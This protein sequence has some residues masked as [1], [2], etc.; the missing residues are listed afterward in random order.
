MAVS[1][2]VKL[3]WRDKEYRA[4]FDAEVEKGLQ[5]TGFVVLT[6]IQ[7]GI[8]RPGTGVRYDHSTAGPY[9]ASRANEPLKSP[10]GELLN[11]IE[12]ETGRIQLG[13]GARLGIGPRLSRFGPIGR[14]MMLGRN[15]RVKGQRPT[16]RPP[17]ERE[18][19]GIVKEWQ[20]SAKRAS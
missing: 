2:A 10:T 12:L 6:A 13:M 1:G 11:S 8:Q 16:L 20:M 4:L 19:P 9:R 18:W 3:A 15:A 17:L 14:Q 5:K 7:K